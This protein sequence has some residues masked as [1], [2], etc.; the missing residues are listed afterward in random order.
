MKGFRPLSGISRSK[1][2]VCHWTLHPGN[3]IDCDVSTCFQ[4]F[5]YAKIAVLCLT[6]DVVP[7]SDTQDGRWASEI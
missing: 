7:G 3:S 4:Y 5:A 2:A 1:N 6:D